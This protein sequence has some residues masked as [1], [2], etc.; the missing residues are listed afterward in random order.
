MQLPILR[1]TYSDANADFRIA[2]P[3]N[4]VPVPVDQGISQGYLRPAP[5]VIQF[6]SA[7][8]TGVDRGGIN[9]NG[10]CY[11]VMGTA[12][13][14]VES[15]GSYT[16][17]G[18]V[19]GTDP[20]TFDYSFTRL[21]I[22]GGGKLY[23]YD[24]SGFQPVSDPDLGTVLSVIYVDGY[25]MTTDGTS[26]VVTELNDPTQVDPLKYGSSEV[27]PD[28]IVAVLKLRD[29]PH[30]VNRYTIEVF[31]NIGGTG[32]PFQRN[33]GAQMT[34]GAVGTNAC[35]LFTSGQNEVIAFV[36]STRNE[37]C[38]IWL[39]ANSVTSKISTREIDTILQE[40]TE[41]QLA[42]SVLESRCDKSHQYLML[43]LPD[44]TLVYDAGASAALQQSVWFVL[45][46]SVVGKSQYRA[47]YHV[48][49][50]DQ[51]IVG[52]PQQA[53]LG[54]LTDSISTHYG[55][56]IGWEFGTQ[57]VY[58]ESKGAQFHT[59][60]LV[61]L[62]GRVVLGA[63]PIVWTSF[64]LDGV[65]WSQERQCPAGKQGDRLRRITWER[66]GDMRNWRIQK[67]RGTSDAF[68]SFAR[69]EAELE[70]LNA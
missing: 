33:E 39:A 53:R 41:S 37:P 63:D 35:C 23:Y 52:D 51:W 68:I 47:K 43:H 25:F 56:T 12:F 64:S 24:G 16:V 61:A 2:Y 70:P 36:G 65:T 26:L 45:T 18:T 9:W 22:A 44:Q 42:A 3:R 50:Y 13:I 48:W 55:A 28:P 10:V 40:Y 57:I 7:P 69:L 46:S 11:R 66:Q 6:L 62:P 54:T 31:N 49:C 19:D 15:S 14:R 5:G 67:F 1:G 21:A 8:E 34:R 59:L 29:E 60:E 30:A 20:V 17:L 4:M 32:F 38:A 27:D 58:N